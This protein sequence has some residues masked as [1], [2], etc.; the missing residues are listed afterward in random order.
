MNSKV[1][2]VADATTGAVIHVSANNPDYGYV[3]LQQVRTVV[4]DNGFLKRQVM[5]ALIQAPVGIL[6]E[7]G[8]YAG[9][10]LDGKIIV[11][12]SLAPFNKKSPERDLKIAGKT[13][14]ACTVDG[15][16]IYRKTVYNTSSN[17]ADVTIQHNNIEE[18]REAYARETAPSK[19][20]QPNEEF[21]L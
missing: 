7:M 10:I 21:T 14:I 13:G 12:E 6:Q 1:V 8:Y 18:L 4:D 9:Q 3:K 15:N 17:A 16:P 20:I 2:I 19:A 5:S 11:K